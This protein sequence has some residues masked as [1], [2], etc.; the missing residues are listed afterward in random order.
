VRRAVL[1]QAAAGKK[2]SAICA[3]PAVVLA[4]LGVLD[5]KQG[6]C[7]PGFERLLDKA[8]YTAALVT[9]DGNITTA[10]G[11]A[12][13]F[14]YAYELLAQLVDKATADQIAEGM[15]YKHLME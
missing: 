2:V 6:T 12:A 7:Y 3:A 14:P 13:A 10:E 5:G 8:Q 1:A 15:R 9:V 11:P 4:Q